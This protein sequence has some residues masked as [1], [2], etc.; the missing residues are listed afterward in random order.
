MTDPNSDPSNFLPSDEDI[1]AEIDSED[2]LTVPS[3]PS[4]KG[5]PVFL[6]KLAALPTKVE[7]LPPEDRGPIMQQVNQLPVEIRAAKEAELVQRRHAELARAAR[8]RVAPQ[9]GVNAVVEEQATLAAEVRQLERETQRIMEELAE[10]ASRDLQSGEATLKHPVGSKSYNDL[11]R[12]LQVLFANIDNLTSGEGAQ[13]RLEQARQRELERRKNRL[14][15]LH[16]H[17][18][19][20]RRG[21]AKLIEEEIESRAENRARMGRVNRV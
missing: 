3:S 13:R 5:D 6:A 4:A 19:A 16:I 20:K 8:L 18:E 14:I 10:V 12:T 7:A 15:D 2:Y 17:Q 11:N 1:L 21:D 9:P